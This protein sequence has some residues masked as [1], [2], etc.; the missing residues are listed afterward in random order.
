M[1]DQSTISRLFAEG[2]R[3]GSARRLRLPRDSMRGSTG[4]RL[5]VSAGSSLDFH[6][7]REYHP[8]DDLRHLDWGVYARSDKEIVKLYREEVEPKLDIVLDTSASMDLADTRKGDASLML[9]A[10]LGAAALGSACTP[11]LWLAGKLLEPSQNPRGASPEEWRVSGFGAASSPYDA[12]LGAAPSFRRNGIR[13]FISDLLWPGEPAAALA[14]LVHGASA[15]F[16]VQLLAASEEE[17]PEHGRYRL[18][19]V[20]TGETLDVFLD[21]PALETY[22]ATLA[23]HRERWSRACAAAG[24]VF[25]SVTDRDVVSDTRLEALERAGLLETT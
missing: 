8:G 20:E 21:G 13:V 9:A 16:V 12:L 17:P 19:D 24:A 23:A 5:G 22:R 15:L 1:K 14:R 4:G 3:I 11:S 6:D 10:A 18:D 25:T 7:Y 2:V